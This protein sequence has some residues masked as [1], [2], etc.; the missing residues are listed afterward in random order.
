MSADIAQIKETLLRPILNVDG[1]D[2]FAHEPFVP[3]AEEVDQWTVDQ[4]KKHNARMKGIATRTTIGMKNNFIETV[5]E[6]CVFAQNKQAF[7][8]LV[9]L[10]QRSHLHSVDCLKRAGIDID[11]IHFADPSRIMTRK[12]ASWDEK[13]TK[14]DALL[15]EP[16]FLTLNDKPAVE[17]AEVAD[18]VRF[19]EALEHTWAVNA[20][21]EACP[22]LAGTLSDEFHKKVIDAIKQEIPFDQDY[23]M[24]ADIIDD[25]YEEIVGRFMYESTAPEIPAAMRDSHKLDERVVQIK[26]I[27][28][29][30]VSRYFNEKATDFIFSTLAADNEI[31]V[32]LKNEGNESRNDKIR[33]IIR[34]AMGFQEKPALA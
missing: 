18:S 22:Q 32:A 26:S 7:Y 10:G 15:N 25:K 12:H 13:I 28:R 4:I 16:G 5:L 21:S 8:S 11:Q 17:K 6:L 34:T 2:F 23:E 30:D 19:E 27:I 1:P 24:L 9:N 20:L 29:R 3:S 31:A 14:L 33:G